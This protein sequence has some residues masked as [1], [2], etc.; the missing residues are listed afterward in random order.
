MT[1]AAVAPTI[2]VLPPDLLCWLPFR[3]AQS[4][5]KKDGTTMAI[6]TQLAILQALG[7]E[8][9]LRIMM[10][11]SHGELRVDDLVRTLERPQSR[12]SRHLAYLKNLGL[13]KDRRQWNQV[14]YAIDTH[15]PLMRD[16]V[17]P[18][19]AAFLAGSKTIGGDYQRL[20]ELVQTNQQEAS[21]PAAGN[22]I[23]VL[24]VCQ[25][26]SMRSQMAEAWLNHVGKPHFQAESAGTYPSTIDPLVVRLMKET[27]LDITLHRT[28][29]CTDLL[30]AG[31]QYDYV[32]T[33]CDESQENPCPVFPGEK[34]RL[35][36][37]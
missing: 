12:I 11:L 10:L 16:M 2:P 20:N 32:I 36:W 13:V 26:N 19:L 3:A 31:K 15:Q 1:L 28:K 35:H 7:D 5:E 27:G 21:N 25:H 8:A 17:L 18:F 34:D 9:R 37:L 33:V 24:F 29:K 6:D 14:F 30:A 22:C 4:T 23:R